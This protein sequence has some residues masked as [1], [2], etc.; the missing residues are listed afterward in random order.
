MF[1]VLAVIFLLFVVPCL[2]LYRLGQWDFPPKKTRQTPAVICFRCSE[3]VAH[4]NIFAITISLVLLKIREFG[5]NVLTMADC[6]DCGYCGRNNFTSRRALTQHQRQNAACAQKA[7]ALL[8]GIDK[9]A[10]V[11]HEFMEFAQILRSSSRKRMI[12][13]ESISSIKLCAKLCASA[14]DKDHIPIDLLEYDEQ[15]YGQRCV[16]YD[17]NSDGDYFPIN[18]DDWEVASDEENSISSHCQPTNCIRG[19]FVQYCEQYPQKFL[20]FFTKP[21]E[22]AIKLLS[23]LRKTKA[24]LETYE[25]VMMWHYCASGVLDEHQGFSDNSDYISRQKMFK[26]L[27]MR[28]NFDETKYNIIKEITLPS[29]RAKAK[30]VINDAAAVFQSLLTD[31]RIQDEDYLF[32]DNDPFSPPPANINTISDINTGLCYTETYRRL[33]QNPTKQVLLPLI[34]YIDGAATGQFVDLKITAVKFTFGIFKRKARERH[35]MWRI[36]GYVPEVS[37]KKTRGQRLFK[38]S[39]HADAAMAHPDS[40]DLFAGDPNKKVPIAQDLHTM[41]ALIWESYLPIQQRGFYWDL[42]YNGKVYKDIEFV[43]FV[44][45]ICCDTEEADRLC[46]AYTS[47]AAGVSQLCRYCTCPTEESDDPLAQYE[48]KTVPMISELV[49][50]NNTQ[51]LKELSQHNIK[52][53]TYLLTFGQH[54]EAGIHGAAP[55]E[56]L[57][58]LLLGIFLYVRDMFFEHTGETSKLSDEI[59]ALCV[60]YGEH[61]SRQSERDMPKTQFTYGI[62]KGKLQAKEFSGVMLV[63]AAV[64]RSTKGK[65]L[66]TDPDNGH[67]N[68]IFVTDVGRYR[69]WIMLLE[70]LLQWESW[71]K[72]DEMLRTDVMKAEHKHR[73]IMYLIRRIGNR[74]RG[75]GLKIT[76]FHA[77]MH[78][79]KDILRFGVPMNYETGAPESGHKP[80][81]NN[82]MKTQK[83]AESFVEQTAT[84][85][86]ES[87]LLS[88]AEEEMQGRPVRNYDHGQQH[89][90]P[91]VKDE[92]QPY[93]GGAKF[94]VKFD[95]ETSKYSMRLLTRIV[96][97]LAV[98]IEQQFIDWL[99]KF[100]EKIEHWIPRIEVRGN[101]HRNGYTFRGS[102]MHMGRV[103]RDWVLIDWGDDG[104]LPCK[105]WGFIDLRLLPENNNVKYANYD[106]IPP[107][108]YAVVESSRLNTDESEVNMSEIFIKIEKEVSQMRN[109]NVTKLKFYLADVE[110]FVEPLT[111]IPDI[112]GVPNG[113]FVCKNREQW[114]QS[115]IDWLREPPEDIPTDYGEIAH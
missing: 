16:E 73:Y 21:E 62:R 83:K 102:P 66:L 12:K 112:G 36:L 44:A 35:H 87:H 64:I 8:F 91:K 6:L 105:I 107:A 19:D 30:M 115:F 90:R 34:F 103:W 113:Y 104:M 52:N 51:K 58:A 17:D 69:D 95:P 96:G 98:R 63:L 45:F 77:I 28:Y 68:A 109:G 24:S 65:L 79:V 100:Q 49:A 14:L 23:I 72:S 67:N 10:K 101:H 11:S 33:I 78:M 42:R 92:R 3:I 31:P 110:A 89:S 46:G 32:F 48:E 15:V 7:Q 25:A 93:L 53:A 50:A 54:N 5:A 22:T 114:R 38:E 43:P 27:K 2:A 82:A 1:Y 99:G 29:S 70:T 9:C 85:N 88:M 61:F 106:G 108:L 56:M 86:N 18:T 84:R 47:R 94:G 60:E 13:A 59:N 81:K 20:P 57:H 97:T 74:T 75:M 26:A 40:I 37:A 111:V 41:L 39:R 71:L 76:K 80:T 55:L 4:A